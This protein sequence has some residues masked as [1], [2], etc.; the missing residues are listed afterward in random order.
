M[1]ATCNGTEGLVPMHAVCIIPETTCHHWDVTTTSGK[2]QRIFTMPSWPVAERKLQAMTAIRRQQ[3]ISRKGPQGTARDHNL[4]RYARPVHGC[5]GSR[6]C[7]SYSPMASINAQRG[8]LYLLA[9]LPRRDGR[10]G[11]AQQRIALRLDDT[12]VNR[13]VAAKQLATL[14]RQLATDTF[15]WA[16]W[17]D[18]REGIT[19]REAIAKLHR[20]RV[21][22][23]RTGERTWEVSY[24][25]RLRQIPPGST[26]TTESIAAA[27]QRYDR[28]SCSYKELWYLLKQLAQLVA[29]PFPEL[30]IPTY[31]RAELVA[32]PSD[33]QII[34]WVELAPDPAQ[35]YFGMMATYGLRPHE[36]E[37]AQLIDKDYLQVAEGGKT[38]F[39][40][41]VPV[42]RE[43]V[44]RF[45][46]RDRRLRDRPTDVAKWLSKTT[47]QLGLSWRPYALRHAYAGRLWRQGG[48]RLDIYTAA[49][50]MGHTATQH[51]KTY[52]AHIQPH[53]VAEAAERALT[54]G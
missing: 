19:W 22:L 31:S 11:L 30:P 7:A 32:V 25:G 39:R 17:T 21:V 41:V 44:E 47:H 10:P 9:N 24:M 18:Q 46:L 53:A 40:T 23:G 8:R 12:P 15:E 6:F 42:P 37:T 14:E 13:R 49:R 1:A 43:W 3:Q 27:L 16:Y 38:G 45:R 2:R 5:I 54:N 29:V 20:A 35:W 28:T 33:A 34:D 36:I 52:R 50:L 4:R 26:V 51:A 48:S